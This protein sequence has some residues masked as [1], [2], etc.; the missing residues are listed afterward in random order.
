M[1]GGKYGAYGE[2]P[3]FHSVAE[4]PLSLRYAPLKGV[5]YYSVPTLDFLHKHL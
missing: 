3:S 5:F 4:R 2:N 1:D